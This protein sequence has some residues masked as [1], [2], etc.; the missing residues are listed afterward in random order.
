MGRDMQA[1]GPH[2]AIVLRRKREK[3]SGKDRKAHRATGILNKL[4]R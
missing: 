1:K 2:K 3:E 4:I